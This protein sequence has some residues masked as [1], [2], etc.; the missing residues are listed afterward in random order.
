MTT[1]VAQSIAAGE[2][3]AR[4]AAVIAEQGYGA[5]DILERTS[6][7][8]RSCYHYVRGEVW[9]RG[10]A[11]AQICAALGLS[12]ARMLRKMSEVDLE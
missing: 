8:R 2:L 3:R 5:I 6:I 1:S 7:K 11:F 12:Q 4:L 10:D 9:P